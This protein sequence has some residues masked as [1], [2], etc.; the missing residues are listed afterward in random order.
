M[1]ERRNMLTSLNAGDLGLDPEILPY[2]NKQRKR[3]TVHSLSFALEKKNG[4]RTAKRAYL[5]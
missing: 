1:K 2:T 5:P 4:K 3:S